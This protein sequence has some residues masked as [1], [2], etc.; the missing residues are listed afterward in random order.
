MGVATACVHGGVDVVSLL[1]R[2]P[3]MGDAASLQLVT[4]SASCVA[5]AACLN[6]LALPARPRSTC[7]Q[8]DGAVWGA[9]PLAA[10]A[11]RGEA[12]SFGPSNSF[13]SGSPRPLGWLGRSVCVASCM[14][15]VLRLDAVMRFPW[16][17]PSAQRASS[18]RRIINN[19]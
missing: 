14:R 15:H 1:G 8:L 17:P 13:G 18:A 3:F 19:T 7:K 2:L 5:G 9:R 11:S 12:G 6:S 4:G 16:R 10:L